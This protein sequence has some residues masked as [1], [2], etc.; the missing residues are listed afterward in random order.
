M[1]KNI[2]RKKIEKPS[3]MVKDNLTNR[4][5]LKKAIAVNK[6]TQDNL[7]CRFCMRPN[8]LN[9]ISMFLQ[10][11][12]MSL[13]L[14]G[15]K[16]SLLKT[17]TVSDDDVTIVDKTGKIISNPQMKQKPNPN[18]VAINKIM[19]TLDMINKS[20]QQ[21]PKSPTA[22]ANQE[23]Q[24]ELEKTT[25]KKASK[26]TSDAKP[27]AK[28]SNVSAKKSKKVPKIGEKLDENKNNG[29]MSLPF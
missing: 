19:S 20:L 8:C 3:F 17:Y 11:Q 27:K 6:S 28:S 25:D 5:A 22:S 9:C 21:E 15:G 29:Q 14:Q 1:L 12:A 4:R 18:A 10:T 24:T 2:F 23:K 26:T 16:S 13:E 7:N